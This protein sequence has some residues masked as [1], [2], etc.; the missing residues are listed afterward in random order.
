MPSP[1]TPSSADYYLSCHCQANLLKLTIPTSAAGVPSA[2]SESDGDEADPEGE[3]EWETISHPSDNSAHSDTVTDSNAN[4]APRAT[5][6][7]VD[8]TRLLAT[9]GQVL[10]CDCSLCV[11]RLIVWSLQP[12]DRIT[13]IRGCERGR[14]TLKS[15]EFGEKVYCHHVRLTAAARERAWWRWR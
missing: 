11:K 12:M 3:G 7:S 14:G 6:Q 15:Y 13:L 8:H 2:P 9:S 4:T 10:V 1:S 5:E